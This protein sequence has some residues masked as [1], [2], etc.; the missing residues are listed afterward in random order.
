VIDV[1]SDIEKVK[2]LI[3]LNLNA[4]N[5][6]PVYDSNSHIKIGVKTRNMREEE[7]I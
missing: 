3:N 1:T 2:Y 7:I 4:I 6:E 5:E